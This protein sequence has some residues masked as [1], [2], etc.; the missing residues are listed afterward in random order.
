MIKLFPCV[1]QGAHRTEIHKEEEG[2]EPTTVLAH[3]QRL[4]WTIGQYGRMGDPQGKCHASL[5]PRGLGEES[6]EEEV[7]GIQVLE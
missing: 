1:R 2:R 4:L 6:G 3:S 7:D 5:S